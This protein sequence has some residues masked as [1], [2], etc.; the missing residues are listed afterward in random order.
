[1]WLKFML[2]RLI[3]SHQVVILCDNFEAYLFFAGQV[4]YHSMNNSPFW[5]LPEHKNLPYCPILTLI[6]MDYADRAPPLTSRANIWPIQASCPTPILWKSWAKQKNAAVLGMP[7]WDIKEL[8][9]GYV[10]A[11]C[12][13]SNVGSSLTTLQFVSQPRVQE[14]SKQTREGP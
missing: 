13:A 6:D 12:L 3:A 1:M 5:N 8:K 4:Y 10:C 7:L 11:P 2:A 9:A 14:I